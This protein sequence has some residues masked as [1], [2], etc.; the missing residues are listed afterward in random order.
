[1]RSVHFMVCKLCLN[2]KNEKDILRLFS[3]RIM[4]SL[5]RECGWRHMMI[6][7]AFGKPKDSGAAGSIVCKGGK[8]LFSMRTNHLSL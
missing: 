6:N 4:I 3:Q 7:E 5:V 2:L 8:Q 1:M